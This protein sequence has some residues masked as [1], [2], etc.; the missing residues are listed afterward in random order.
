[1]KIKFIASAAVLALITSCGSNSDSKAVASDTTAS[2]VTAAAK[3]ATESVADVVV[4]A[5]Q[6]TL[7]SVL[8]YGK[9]GEIRT[10]GDKPVVIDFNATWCGPCVAFSPIFHKV[11]AEMESKALFLSVDVDRSPRAADDF[12]VSSIPMVSIV[13]PDG[14]VDNHVGYMG[15]EEFVRVLNSSFADKH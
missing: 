3:Q 14:V 2:T 5:D 12:G 10:R 11:A 13:F 9:S 15:Q 1:M 6:A 8:V 7:D 4:E